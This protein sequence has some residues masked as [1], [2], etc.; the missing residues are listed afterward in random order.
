MMLIVSDAC[1]VSKHMAGVL[2]CKLQKLQGVPYPGLPKR[3]KP[4]RV[5]LYFSSWII[6]AGKNC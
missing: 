3:D 1:H 6:R 2:T 5:E 4:R